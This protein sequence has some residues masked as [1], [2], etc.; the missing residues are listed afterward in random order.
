LNQILPDSFIIHQD[1]NTLYS[2]SIGANYAEL[3]GFCTGKYIISSVKFTVTHRV[4]AQSLIPIHPIYSVQ[5]WD[6]A[7]GAI[8]WPLFTSFLR[9]VKLTGCIPPD[10]R[11]HD[12]LN[13]QKEM[14]VGNELE[15]KWK[16]VF[17]EFKAKRHEDGERVVW[18]LV[19][20]FLL[21]WKQV[22]I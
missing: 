17:E 22:Q 21:Y 8:D 3:I 9:R 6:A 15:G 18:G 1:V 14:P 10:H 12:H 2:H 7:S 11:S 20:G 19:D 4:Q 5:D 16:A 13:E